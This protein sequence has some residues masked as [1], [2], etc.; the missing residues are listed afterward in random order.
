[1]LWT[2][3]LLSISLRN[4]VYVFHRYHCDAGALLKACFGEVDFPLCLQDY[5]E[6]VYLLGYQEK[7]NY[8]KL[9]QLFTKQLRALGCRGDGRDTLDWITSSKVCCCPH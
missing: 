2:A 5:M 7:P 3:Q 8:I 4:I 6:A 9:K 1:M